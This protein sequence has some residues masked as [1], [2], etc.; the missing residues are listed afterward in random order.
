MTYQTGKEIPCRFCLIL[1][2]K[3]DKER[4][5]AFT[6]K[7]KAATKIKTIIYPLAFV[8]IVILSTVYKFV[9][10]DNADYSLRAFKSGRTAEVTEPSA[11]ET[12]AADTEEES[13][14]VS[15]SAAVTTVEYVSVYICGEVCNPGI[16]D[17]PK[18]VMLNDI[19]EDA[20]GLTPEAS[21]DNINLVYQISCNMSIYIPSEEEIREGYSGSDVIRADG[22]YV[23]GNIQGSDTGSSGSAVLMVNINTAGVEELKSLPGIGDVTAQAIVD[24]RKGT[25]FEKIDDIKNVTGIGDS[26]FERIKDY[27]CV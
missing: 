17:A 27:I 11:S 19:I 9:L 25:P 18:G 6:M 8:L 21:A 16:Y 3:T 10:K 23:W 24:Y 7:N 4:C 20:G 1:S 26:K 12:S 13:S 5:Y 22:V 14:A 15:S 2:K